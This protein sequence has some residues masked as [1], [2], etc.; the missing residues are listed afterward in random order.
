G[1]AA[2]PGRKAD[3]SRGPRDVVGALAQV[4][5]TVRADHA[6]AADRAIALCWLLHLVG[7][8]HQPLHACELYSAQFPK[9]DQGGNAIVVLRDPPYTNSQMSLHLLWDSLPGNYKADRTLEEVVTGL[10]PDPLLAPHNLRTALGERD[11]GAWAK[12]SKALAGE[13]AYLDGHLVGGEAHAARGEGH[14]RVPGVPEGYVEKAEKVAMQRIAL[15]GYRLADF[16]N[17]AFDKT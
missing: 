16:L 11:F 1:D 13:Y 8:V 15:A 17:A 6:A 7:D 3:D 2:V 10:R 4:A 12:E 5:A 9:G 14:A